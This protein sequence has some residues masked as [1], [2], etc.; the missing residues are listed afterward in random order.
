VAA[1]RALEAKCEVVLMGK[2]GVDG[3]Y[4]ADPR[5]DPTATK[6]DELTYSDALQ[7]G[8]RVA[9]ATAFA[10][11]MENKLPMIVF[12]LQDEGAIARAVRGEKIGTYVGSD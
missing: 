1:Q 5:H 8:L 10:L 2:N 4:T 3:V 7:R 9:D 12:G 11:C 6:I